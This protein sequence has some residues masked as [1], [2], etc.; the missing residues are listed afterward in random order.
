MKINMKCNEATHVCDKAQYKEAGFWE[1]LSMK[2]HHIY[3]RIC[4][5]HA[6]RNTKLTHLFQRANL[7]TL[8][9]SEKEAI[10]QRLGQDLD[11]Q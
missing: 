4:R 2:I 10:K 8:T 6:I 11:R 3:C 1:R 9:A 7:K 5:Q